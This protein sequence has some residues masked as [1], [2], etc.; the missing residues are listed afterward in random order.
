MNLL[1]LNHN[2]R[3]RGTYFRARMFGRWL[4]EAGHGVTLLTCADRRQ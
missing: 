1:L 4:A 2:L 3:E